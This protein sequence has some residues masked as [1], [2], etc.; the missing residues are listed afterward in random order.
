MMAA[1][2]TERSG[3]FI[4]LPPTSVHS[5]QEDNFMNS[6]G[7]LSPEAAS[8]RSVSGHKVRLGVVAGGDR[9][10]GRGGTGSVRVEPDIMLV[11]N[12]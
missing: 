10:I 5:P 2:R 12:K 4:F 8:R 7:S 6:N 9:A 1:M 11:T 3:H